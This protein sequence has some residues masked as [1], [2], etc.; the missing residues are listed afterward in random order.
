MVADSGSGVVAD[1]RSGVVAGAVSGV[2]VDSESG[3]EIL[4][5]L[6]DCTRDEKRTL[7]MVTHDPGAASVGD[8]TIRLVDGRVATTTSTPAAP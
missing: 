6:R 4:Q 5:L 2:V 8:R 3:A 7:V 1:S